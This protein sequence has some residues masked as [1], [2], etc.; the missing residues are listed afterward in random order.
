MGKKVMGYR[1]FVYYKTYKDNIFV[2]DGRA[3]ST[4]NRPIASI[5][6][7]KPIE[8]EIDKTLSHG[9]T[10]LTTNYRLMARQIDGVW[11]S[12]DE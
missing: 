3:E 7:L 9:R 4:T 6:G 1:Y 12:A 5:D 2:G 10:C 11:V 8:A